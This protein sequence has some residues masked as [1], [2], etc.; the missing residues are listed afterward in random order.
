MSE[1]VKKC[2]GIA[3][4]KEAFECLRQVVKHSEDKCKPRIVLLTREGCSGCDEEKLRYKNDIEAGV[5]TQVDIFTEEGKEIARKNDV[6]A[7]PA[8]LVVDCQDKA[9]E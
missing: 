7:V 2:Y 9:I 5:V 3:E 8:I 4:D 6:Y 1:A